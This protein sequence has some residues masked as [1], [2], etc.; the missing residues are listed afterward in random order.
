V[1]ATISNCSNNYGPRQHVEK[2]IP[3][4][5]T[6]VLD[7]AAIKIY[8]TG[9]NVRDW[10]HVDDHNDAILKVIECGKIG[11]TYL[12]GANGERSNVEIAMMINEI[13]G[14][15]PGEFEFVQDRKGHD[16]RYA[17]DSSKISNELG[18]VPNITSIESGLERTVRWYKANEAWWREQKQ[19][20]EAAYRR[21]E[22]LADE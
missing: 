19:A 14:R 6:N 9:K 18:W 7:G 10:I 5:I 13:M 4:Q 8:G 1:R 15:S 3:R 2:F 21:F 17:I 22:D 12:I 16:L 20:T 11:D